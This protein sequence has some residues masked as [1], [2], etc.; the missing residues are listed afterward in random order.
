MNVVCTNKNVCCIL[1]SYNYSRAGKP[2]AVSAFFGA[3]Y[4]WF[5]KCF[6]AFLAMDM[7]M[8]MALAGY[9]YGYGYFHL[10]T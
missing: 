3:F 1:K 9:G 10:A 4:I 6:C 8:A 5:T 2:S 7:A